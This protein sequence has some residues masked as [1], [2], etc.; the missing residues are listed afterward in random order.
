MQKSA[1]SDVVFFFLYKWLK[2]PKIVRKTILQRMVARNYGKYYTIDIAKD[3]VNRNGG[4]T[5][6]NY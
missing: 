6:G 1:S 5:H 2:K 3:V 4:Y